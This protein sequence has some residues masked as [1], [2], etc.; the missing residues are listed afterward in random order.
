MSERLSFSHPLILDLFIHNTAPTGAR[1][2][3]IHNSFDLAYRNSC[4][5]QPPK[6]SCL[7]RLQISYHFR[8]LAASSPYT[9]PNLHLLLL[10]PFTPLNL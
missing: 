8:P 2:H 7:L 10:I 4:K 3:R 9:L 1:D 5:P 6:F